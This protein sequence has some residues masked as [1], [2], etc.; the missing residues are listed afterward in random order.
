VCGRGVG[1]SWD[2]V[3]KSSHSLGKSMASTYDEPDSESGPR[4]QGLHTLLGR[5]LSSCFLGVLSVLRR[6]CFRPKV[7]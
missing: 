6:L 5:L 1:Y 3:K 4:L 2:S 7:W